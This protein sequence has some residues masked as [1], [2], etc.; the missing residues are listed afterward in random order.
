[1]AYFKGDE[2]DHDTISDEINYLRAILGMPPITFKTIPCHQCHELFS[3]QFIGPKKQVHYCQT[4]HYRMGRAD[5]REPH[6][7]GVN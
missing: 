1:M 5:Q 3:A 4:C 2:S 7:E 6:D